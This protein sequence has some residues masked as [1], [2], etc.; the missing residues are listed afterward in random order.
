MNKEIEM[1]Y[2]TLEA[3]DKIINTQALEIARLKDN[4]KQYIYEHKLYQKEITRL[5]E[6]NQEIYDGFKVAIDEVCETDREKR[7]YKQ[8][9]DK[10][11]EYI[12]TT[13]KWLCRVNENL[14][15]EAIAKDKLLEILEGDKEN[16]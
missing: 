11:I 5:K 10:A 8:K 7:E 2:K 6:K 12:N 15:V 14:C 1:L 16:E 3:K 9:I 13:D 4:V